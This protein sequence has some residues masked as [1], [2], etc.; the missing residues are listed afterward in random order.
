[1][2]KNEDAAAKKK[3][4]TSAAQIRVQKGMVQFL[5]CHHR[6]L[7]LTRRSCASFRRD[8]EQL[9]DLT[10][11]EL[12]DTM[13]TDFPDPTDLLNFTL[14]ITPDEGASPTCALYGHHFTP[15]SGMYKGGSFKFSFA[16]NSNYP[17]EPPK[18][19]CM[20]TVRV[21]T[22]SSVLC[23]SDSYSTDIPP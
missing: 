19:K 11:L 15:L 9:T 12:P 13:K 17:H 1:M 3:P 14:T 23:V 7:R 10:E 5:A 16:I 2:K 18:V 21:D 8:G 6:C 4:K 22:P 20:Q